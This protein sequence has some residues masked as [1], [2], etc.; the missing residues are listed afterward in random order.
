VV[1]AVVAT[2]SWAAAVAGERVPQRILLG[3]TADPAHSQTVTWRTLANVELPQAQITPWSAN[4]LSESGATIVKATATTLSVGEGVNA[5]HYLATF[6]ALEPGKE[7]GYRV[8]DGKLWS[9]WNHFRTASAGPEKFRFIYLGDA[10]RDVKSQWSRVARMA[11]L[12]APDA[13]FIAHAGDLIEEG[14]DDALWGE[15]CDG[16][17]FIGAMFPNVAAPGNHDMNL[18]RA[19]AKTHKPVSVSPLWR[20][21]LAFPS[22]GPADAPMLA[23]EAYYV[24]YQGMRLIAFEANAFSDEEYDPDAR[25]IVQKKEIEWVEKVLKDNPNKW[26]VVLHHE[27]VYKS[28][29]NSDNPL[30]R[31]AF[32]PLYDKYH[33][34]LVLQGHD[35]CYARS[36]KLAGN[37]VVDPAAPGTV[38]VVSVSG[39][40]M[41]PYDPLY[42][43]LMAK[44]LSN[45]QMFQTVEIDGD[46]L[47]YDAYSAAGTKVDSFELRKRGAS[48]STYTDL[49]ATAEPAAKPK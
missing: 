4:P 47:K 39:P 40:R 2:S 28:G 43:S 36:A 31:D 18:P 34:D 29:K 14:Y 26:T 38:Y 24:D 8:G 33:V 46:R 12:Q 37:K 22:N 11:V 20:A 27:P 48:G 45:T 1:I 7:Y 23:D 10:Q 35:H 16:L 9:E 49:S 19:E 42:Q 21:H 5:T 41:Y 30:L 3:I 25:Q 44:T 15:W 32:V 17:G 13:R 6:S